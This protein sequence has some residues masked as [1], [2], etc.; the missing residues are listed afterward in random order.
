MGSERGEPQRREKS[1]E[2][3]LGCSAV[4]PRPEPFHQTGGP[5]PQLG[6]SWLRVALICPLSVNGEFPSTDNSCFTQ[7]VTPQ[8]NGPQPLA[9]GSMRITAGSPCFKKDNPTQRCSSNSRASP[10]QAKAEMYLRPPPC[11]ALSCLNPSS[12]VS[13]DVNSPRK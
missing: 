5:F 2:F 12:H 13:P 10:D 7:E 6:E 4:E 3:P 8:G 11:L 1:L 9:G